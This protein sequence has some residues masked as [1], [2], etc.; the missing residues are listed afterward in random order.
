MKYVVKKIHI[1]DSMTPEQY[2]D[3]VSRAP[4]RYF[5]TLSEVTAY[6]G[7]RL[8]RCGSGYAGSIGNTAFVAYKIA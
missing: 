8:Y 5:R 4:I 1:T 6:C 3:A 2:N 7:G